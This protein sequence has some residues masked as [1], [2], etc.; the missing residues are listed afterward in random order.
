M[1]AQQ[2][3]YPAVV[4][5]RHW[6]LLKANAGAVRLVEFLSDRSHQGRRST[7]PTRWSHRMSCGPTCQ[8]TRVVRHFIRTVEADAKADGLIETRPSS[9]GS[10]ATG[11]FGAP[12]GTGP[13]Q[14]RKRAG[15]AMH[16]ARARPPRLVHNHRDPGHAAG[17]HI[18]G[19]AGRVSSQW[20][21]RPQSSC[22]AG[23]I[24]H[25]G[26]LVWRETDSLGLAAGRLIHP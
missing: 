7:S 15:P 8:L 12:L 23:P 11:A 25:D 1:L 19:A 14:C 10:W 22:E 20:M 18:A 9:N 5:D 6:N 16:F 2:Q 13:E 4:V 3:P 24:R 17:H 21:R 26:V